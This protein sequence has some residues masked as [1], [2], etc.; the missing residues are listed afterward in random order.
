MGYRLAVAVLA[1]LVVLLVVASYA[2]AI[3][4]AAQTEAGYIISSGV[5]ID[6]FQPHAYQA[7]NVSAQARAEVLC[8][9]ESNSS[10]LELLVI[11]RQNF[12]NF[13]HGLPFTAVVNYTATGN[14]LEVPGNVTFG[15]GNYTV[16]IYNPSSQ[17]VTVYVLAPCEVRAD[18]N[19]W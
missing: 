14:M 2:A 17:E 9:L 13:T 1:V 6:Y 11:P 19:P 8:E 16:L 4:G 3:D 15:P 5:S 10:G 12:Y 7:L 18:V